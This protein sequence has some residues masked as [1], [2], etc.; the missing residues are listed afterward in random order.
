MS[1]M[2]ISIANRKSIKN[3]FILLISCSNFQIL[4][5]NNETFWRETNPQLTVC[6]KQ[7]VLIW[8]PCAYLW[9]FSLIDLRRRAKSR[10]SDIPWSLVNLSKLLC[11]ILLICL[12]I[13]DLVMMLTIA[14]T[15]EIYSV[16]YVSLGI[17]LVTFVSIISNLLFC[18]SNSNEILIFI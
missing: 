9:L 3:D 15:G 17:K 4:F 10:Y 12:T 11:I 8:I 7:T 6:F 14:D 18:F 13:V 2:F 1:Y 16:Q 5:Q